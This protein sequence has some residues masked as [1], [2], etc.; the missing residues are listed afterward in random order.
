MLNKLDAMPTS[1]CQPI[2]CFDSGCRYKFTYWMTNSAHSDQLASEGANWFGST[3]FA[4]GISGFSR[5]RVNSLANQNCRIK[6][7]QKFK[8]SLLA[9]NKNF[10]TAEITSYSYYHIYPKYWDTLSYL[11]TI[12]VFTFVMLNKWRCHTHFKFS[13][14]QFTW[15]RLLIQIHSTN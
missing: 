6:K 1:I 15:S 9:N 7:L 3:L 12:L 8:Y 14:N 13:A 4:K 5:T 10:L 11:L 2:R